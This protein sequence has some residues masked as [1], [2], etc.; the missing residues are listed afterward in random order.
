LQSITITPPKQL[1]F[2]QKADW[3]PNPQ[4]YRWIFVDFQDARMAQRE[5]LC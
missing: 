5:R 3:L 1:R 2:E 4:G